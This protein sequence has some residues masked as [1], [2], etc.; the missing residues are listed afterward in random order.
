MHKKSG[1]AVAVKVVKKAPVVKVKK[2]VP[3]KPTY[4]SPVKAVKKPT[5]PSTSYNI[6]KS[7]VRPAKLPSATILKKQKKKAPSLVI[8]DKKSHIN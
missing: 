7:P 2:V 5:Y 1:A 3:R 4:A 8:Y 6:K